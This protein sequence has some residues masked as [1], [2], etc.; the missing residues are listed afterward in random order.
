MAD[1]LDGFFVDALVDELDHALLLVVHLQGAVLGVDEIGGGV[2]DRAQGG[3]E[4][5]AGGDHQHRFQQPV[6]AVTAFDD[7]PDTILNLDQKLT[8]AQRRQAVPQRA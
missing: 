8:Q 4:F 7:L 1:A 2:H 3:V 6:E 5:Q